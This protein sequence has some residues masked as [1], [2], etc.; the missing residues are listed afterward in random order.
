MLLTPASNKRHS[1]INLVSLFGRE[2]VRE[3]VSSAL[4]PYQVNAKELNKLPNGLY[5]LY[6]S[7][8]GYKIV[9][10]IVKTGG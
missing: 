3:V 4:F 9:E 1:R 8:D 5:Y 10:K 6:I 2:V 7:F